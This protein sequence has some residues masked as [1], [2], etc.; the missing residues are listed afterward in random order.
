MNCSRPSRSGSTPIS[1]WARVDVE[2]VVIPVSRDRM[3][4]GLLE[5]LGDIAAGNLTITPERE[6]AVSISPARS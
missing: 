4:P 5:G 3:I 6:G 2:V 1:A